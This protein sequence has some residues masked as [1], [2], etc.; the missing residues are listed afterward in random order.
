MKNSIGLAVIFI[1]LPIS[2]ASAETSI[3]A[4]VNKTSITTDETLTY[5]ITVTSSEKLLPLPQLP[6][7][8]GF[9]VVSQ[10]QSSQISFSRKE[11]KVIITYDFILVPTTIGKFKIEPSIIKI[12]NKTYSTDA[13][14]IEVTQGKTKPQTKPEERPFQPEELQPE[15]EEPQITL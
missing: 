7:F 4:Q 12:K 10:A 9:E 1:F 5:K 11:N 8:E 14:E 6:K 3:K 15:T 13:F 2:M